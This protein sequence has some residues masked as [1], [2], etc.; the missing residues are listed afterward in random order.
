MKKD[1]V[2]YRIGKFPLQANSRARAVSETQGFVK[3]L[4]DAAT[5]KILGVHIIAPDAGTLIHECVVAMEFSGSAEDLAR[6]FH[7]HPTFN[8]AIKE[9]AWAAFNTQAIHI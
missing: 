5:D 9:A 6:S 4:A 1:N 2:S 3:V 7:A 8:E